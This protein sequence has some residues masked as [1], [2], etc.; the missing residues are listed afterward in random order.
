M[1]DHPYRPEAGDDSEYLLS[2]AATLMSG[3]TLLMRLH[4]LS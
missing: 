3:A 2:V 4:T 1:S